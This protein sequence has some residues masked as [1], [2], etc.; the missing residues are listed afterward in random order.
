MASTAALWWLCLG[1]PATLAEGRPDAGQAPGGWGEATEVRSAE[2]ETRKPTATNA[3]AGAARSGT[4]KVVKSKAGRGTTEPMNVALGYAIGGDAARTVFSLELGSPTDY[5]TRSLANPP[6]V[7]LD[8]PE[9]EFRLADGAGRAGKGLIT[10]FRFGLIEAGKSRVVIDTAG[11]VRV[12]RAEL[13]LGEA[14]EAF[15]LEIELVSTTAGEL[16]AAELAEAALNLKPTFPEPKPVPRTDPPER[17]VIVV[18]AG[19]GGIDSGASGSKIAEKDLVLAVALRIER[20]LRE[21]RGYDVIMTRTKDVFVSLDERVDVARRHAADLFVSVHA[22]SL[23]RREAARTVRGATVYTLADQASDE[24]TRQV[25]DKEN[26]VD[27]L[28]GLPMSRVADDQVRDILI[29]LMRRET[30]SFASQFRESLLSELRGGVLL[31]RDPRRSGPFK[32]LKQPSSPAVLV[33][34]GYI[35]NAED[36]R[37]MMKPEWQARVASS[38]VRAVREHFRQRLAARR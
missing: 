32:V 7:I 22:D 3:G 26:A 16:A 11:P 18:D 29:D 21:T 4:R 27:L 33:E 9:T 28:A 25:A 5:G 30:L 20:T 17:P 31:S 38:V 6:R 10:A 35:S 14:G 15:R 24:L 12:E 13:S 34:L 1:A 8:L 19:H 37:I 23:A 36:E 2:R